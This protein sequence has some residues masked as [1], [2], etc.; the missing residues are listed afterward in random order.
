MKNRLVE[1]IQQEMCI[2]HAKLL[3]EHSWR[4]NEIL[5]FVPNL[6]QIMIHTMTL[7][8]ELNIHMELC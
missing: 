8:C 3:L 2:L 4:I 1:F 5:Y 6:I 7:G